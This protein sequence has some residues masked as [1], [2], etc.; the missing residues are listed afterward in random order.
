MK[1]RVY[2]LDLLR[3]FA[4]LMVILLHSIGTYLTPRLY[5][6][7]SWL[8]FLSVNA[9]TRTGVPLFLMI[10]GAL[11]LSSE[12]TADMGRFYKKRITHL[13]LPLLFWNAAYFVYNSLLGQ[14]VFDPAAFLSKLLNSGT[15]YHLW[16]MYTM[17]AIYLVAPFLKML[18]DKCTLKQL[19]WLMI[20]MTFGTTLRPFINTVTPLYLYLFDPLFNGYIGCFLLGYILYKTDYNKVRVSLAALTGVAALIFSVYIHHT[21]S[22]EKALNLI[23]NNGY[24]LCHYALAAAIFVLI[25]CL[26]E[27]KAPLA[28]AVALLSKLSFGMYLLH[29][30]VIEL[31]RRF[32]MIDGTPIVCSAYVF[33]LSTAVS[34][35]AAFLLSKIKYVRKLVI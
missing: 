1:Q 30:A 25:K 8:P 9:L 31:I 23:L 10:S 20:L 14:S 4:I 34:L 17:I 35:L 12:G 16:Y 33:L 7:A 3:G 22:S 15:K 24:S 13:L 32:I 27:R 21:K 28:G 29:V 5:G 19:T 18:V 6:T 2:Y 26:F 11:L